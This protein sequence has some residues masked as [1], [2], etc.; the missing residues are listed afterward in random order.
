MSDY[1][2]G[3]I[4]KNSYKNTNVF[5]DKT[6]T[7][8]SAI[9]DI[10]RRDLNHFIRAIT[11]AGSY[12]NEGLLA[13]DDVTISNRKKLF[14]LG[15]NFTEAQAIFGFN[16]LVYLGDIYQK[17]VLPPSVVSENLT[18]TYPI[19]NSYEINFRSYINALINIYIAV[20]NVVLDD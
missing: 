20:S 10:S 19:A 15:D 5:L 8:F 16:V 9:Q 13:N 11:E 17:R 7:T 12:N 3:T 14:L 1:Y 2:V 18:P 6:Y 4:T